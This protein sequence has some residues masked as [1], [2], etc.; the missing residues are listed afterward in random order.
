METKSRILLIDDEE[1]VIDSCSQILAG[2][3]YEIASASDG[4]AG[5]RL[6]SEFHPDLVFVDLKMP[7]ISGFEVIEKIRETDR[8]HKG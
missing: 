2:G 8:C 6:V 4:T 7:G 5:L 1:V 3:P